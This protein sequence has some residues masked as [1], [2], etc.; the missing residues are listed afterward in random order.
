MQKIFYWIATMLQLLL[1]IAAYG[2]H[3]FSIKKMGMMR[4]VVFMNHQWEELF[5]LHQLQ[6]V[7]VAILILIDL[8]IAAKLT[9]IKKDCSFASKMILP[10][11]IMLT[12]LT[13]AFA[14]LTFAFSTDNFRSF[15]FVSLILVIITLIQDLKI[16][17]YLKKRVWL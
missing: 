1:F 6:Y 3:I 14:L 12:I 16:F 9:K 17:I 11:V 15:Y 8:I 7:A 2:I 10:M 5:P 4:Y 13:T